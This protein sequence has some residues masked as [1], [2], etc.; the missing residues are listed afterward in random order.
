MKKRLLQH[1][2]KGAGWAKAQKSISEAA[3]LLDR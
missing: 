3:R 1:R 2:N